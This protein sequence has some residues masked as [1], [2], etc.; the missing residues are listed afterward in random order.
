MR[1]L[2]VH[3]AVQQRGFNPRTHKGCDLSELTDGIGQFTFQ[4]THP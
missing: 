1:L 4:S 3:T 2:D